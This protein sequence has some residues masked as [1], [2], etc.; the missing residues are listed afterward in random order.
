MKR[1]KLIKKTRLSLTNTL[2]AKIK[3]TLCTAVQLNHYLIYLGNRNLYRK[4]VKKNSLF[5]TTK[6]LKRKNPT[7]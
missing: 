5:F 2:G 1:I 7:F 6:T 3:H 4:F